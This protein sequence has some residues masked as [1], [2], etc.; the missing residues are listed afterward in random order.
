M[1]PFGLIF[2]V[3]RLLDERTRPATLRLL[4]WVFKLMIAS[5]A[6]GALF[7]VAEH[8]GRGPGRAGRAPSRADV[9]RLSDLPVP[10][11]SASPVKSPVP[12]IGEPAGAPSGPVA[13]SAAQAPAPGPDCL[14]EQIEV[15]ATRLSVP[16][17]WPVTIERYNT[18]AR[19]F[20]SRCGTPLRDPSALHLPGAAE[21]GLLV[22]AA[23]AQVRAWMLEELRQRA[24]GGLQ[25]DTAAASSTSPGLSDAVDALAGKAG[26]TPAE[27]AALH[28]ICLPAR[29]RE[30]ASEQRC[31]REQLAA[32]NGD[33]GPVTLAALP[34]DD[35]ESLQLAC[36]GTAAVG[37]LELRQCERRQL[38]DLSGAPGASAS[39]LPQ[40]QESLAL[41]CLTEKAQGPASLRQCQ[42]HLLQ[43]RSERPDLS[44]VSPAQYQTAAAECLAEEPLGPGALD[45]CLAENLRARR[46]Y[47]R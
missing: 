5:I 47:S 38:A 6:V 36:L 1:H 42:Q 22:K 13:G 2:L 40:E 18:L 46:A 25:A 44:G 28:R 12:A 15:E 16:Q 30:P 34:V 20:G 29:L 14:T 35:Q 21:L 11:S 32:V 7:A 4:K 27:N 26:V 37:L 17:G 19:E 9:A 43:E 45:V 39:L 10:R 8:A 33:A 23:Q 3:F 41:G 31:V 24:A